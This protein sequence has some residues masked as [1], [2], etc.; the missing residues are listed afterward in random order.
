MVVQTKIYDVVVLY[1]LIN[2]ACLPVPPSRHKYKWVR[3]DLNPYITLSVGS[4]H[5]KI[6]TLTMRLPISPPTH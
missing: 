6:A 4:Y 5:P 3:K 1:L 2:L